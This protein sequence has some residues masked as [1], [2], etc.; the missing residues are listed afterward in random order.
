MAATEKIMKMMSEVEKFGEFTYTAK[1]Y[2][3][4]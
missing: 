1:D 3:I 2:I 4:K